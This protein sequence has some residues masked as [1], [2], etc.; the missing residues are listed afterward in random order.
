[1][2]W[3][4]SKSANNAMFSNTSLM[5]K[6]PIISLTEILE[7]SDL[8][9]YSEVKFVVLMNKWNSQ[10]ISDY[11]KGKDFT[12]VASWQA[13]HD[14]AVSVDATGW[15]N[16]LMEKSFHP[17]RCSVY[18]TVGKFFTGRLNISDALL[19]SKGKVENKGDLFS[20][21]TYFLYKETIILNFEIQ[22]TDTVYLLNVHM[23]LMKIAL[24]V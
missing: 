16:I 22:L 13:V 11:H 21:K 24:S 8:S 10:L 6:S 5:K 18:N 23:L 7:E 12:V 20:V 15:I 19:F 14:L 2:Q 3:R 17:Q 4:E 9:S 1:M